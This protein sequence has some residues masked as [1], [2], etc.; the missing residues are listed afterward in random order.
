MSRQWWPA[1]PKDILV[2]CNVFWIFVVTMPSI[3]GLQC[4]LNICGDYASEHEI[5][6]NCNETICVLFCPKNITCPTKCFSKWCTCATFWPREIP[7]CVDKCITEGWWWYSETSE[8]TMMCCK[9]TQRRF[10]SVLSCSKKH[11]ILCL[12]HANLCLPTVK[13]IY[14]DQYEALTCCV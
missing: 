13:Q 6:F 9:Q 11:S 8:I 5:T 7:W 2:N 10:W 3:S 12:L 4:L 1:N 14:T